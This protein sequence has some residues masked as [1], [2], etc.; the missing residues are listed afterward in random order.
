MAEMQQSMDDRFAGRASMI[1]NLEVD[2]KNVMITLAAA[3]TLSACGNVDE[4][5]KNAAPVRYDSASMAQDS[6]QLKI[7]DI[8]FDNVTEIRAIAR[9]LGKDGPPFMSYVVSRAEGRAMQS[10]PDIARPDG[11]APETVAEAIE[12][13]KIVRE[14]RAAARAEAP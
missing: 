9:S 10:T 11:S 2:M 3:L 12:L 1:S 7:A 8:D 13:A 5:S 14:K 6:L 4:T